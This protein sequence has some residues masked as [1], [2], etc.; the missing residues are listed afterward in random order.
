MAVL[1]LPLS[2]TNS[3]WSQDYRKGLEVLYN[4]L[5]Q[6]VAENDEIIEFIRARAIAE[7]NIAA[8]LSHTAGSGPPGSGF[9]VDDGA[10]LL[11]AFRG[12]QSEA[13][14]QGESHRNIA[15]E[16]HTLVAD[17]FA[18]W[19]KGHRE[20]LNASQAAVVDGYLRSYESAQKEVIKLKNQY[21]SKVRKADEAADDAKFAPNTELAG[22]KYTTSPR[23]GPV[24]S[25]APPQRGLS[26][27]ERISQ[28]LKEVQ[29]KTATATSSPQA[30]PTADPDELHLTVE[31]EN[32]KGKGKA[33]DVPESMSPVPMSPAPL[34]PPKLDIPTSPMPP[35][36]PSP[37]LLGGLS[38]PPT[39]ISDLLTRAAAEL[40]LRPVRFPILGEYQD[41]FTGEEFVVWLQSNVAGLGDS[42]DKAEDAAKDLTE[43]DGLLRRIGELGNL[44]DSA[45]DAFYQFRPKAFE[46]GKTTSKQDFSVA[47]PAR[48]GSGDNILKRSNNFLYVVSKALTA[49]NHGEPPHIRARAEADAADKAYRIAIRKLDRQRLGLEERMEETLRI[50]QKLEMDRLRAVKTVLLQ[51]HGTLSNL[52]KSLEP[53]MERS[54][55]HIAAYLPEADLTALIERYRTGPFRPTPQVYESVAHDEADV[56]FGIDLRRWADGGWG[57]LHNGTE[58][59][60]IIPPVLSALLEGLQQAYPKL[61]NDDEKRKSWIYEVPLPAVHHLRESLNA[62]EP[63]QLIPQEMLTRYD[64]PVLASTVKLWMLELDPPLALW[65]GWEDIRRIYPSVGSAKTTDESSDKQRIES[66]RD[67]LQR[68]PKVHLFVLDAIISHIRSL[69]EETD[70][71]ETNEVYVTKLALSIGRTILRPKFETSV[72]LQDRHPAMFFIDLINLYTEILPPTIAKKKTEA[73]RR[74]PLR[75]RTAPIDMRMSRSRLSVGA[76]AREWLAMQ[77]S[78]GDIP[79]PVPPVPVAAPVAVPASPA[80]EPEPEA[81]A[82]DESAQQEPVAASPVSVTAPAP[83]KPSP[84]VDPSIPPRPA[85]RSPPPELDD[86]PPRPPMF[87]E[88][89]LDDVSPVPRPK[90]ADPPPEPEDGAPA[91]EPDPSVFVSP[92]TP[93]RQASLTTRSTSPRVQV[94]SPVSPTLASPLSA[95]ASRSPSPLASEDQPLNPHR[96]SLSRNSSNQADASRMRGPRGSRPARTGG[97][98]SVSAIVSNLNRNSSQ[99]STPGSPRSTSPPSAGG[100]GGYKGRRPLS[101]ISDDKR[102]S[103]TSGRGLLRRTMDSDAEENLVG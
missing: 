95:T 92:P 40:P 49:N 39:A 57:A 50:L 67:A 84:P 28:R 4:K 70:V 18:E 85:F 90:F 98:G 42:F 45:D 8:A 47:P 62:V 81:E 72:S 44:F 100:A 10:T 75:K 25:R 102:R 17:P 32:S 69:I 91:E 43:R 83:S 88:P 29:R 74:M 35:A 30:V 79:P 2:F 77:R 3:F 7:A 36:P 71:A 63:E 73:E 33:S 76:E 27:S 51:Y 93:A 31:T 94:R 34:L 26:I 66:L 60:E 24:D 12:L 101:G 59:K 78:Q 54:N 15:H 19:A 56:V 9:S 96:T 53:S 87:K 38:L 99:G 64:A 65:E 82:V 13:A 52:P 103:L 1:S 55:T 14:K 23:L 68:W 58:K 37:M 21:L 16:L 46:L 97:G 41:C 86:L 20:R 11:M 48:L 80:P 6:G 61:R 89:D 22:D 5:Q